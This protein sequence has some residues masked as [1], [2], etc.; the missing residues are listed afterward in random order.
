M[1]QRKRRAVFF[2]RD[3][4]LNVDTGY[5]SQPSDVALVEHAAESA[6]KLADAG[7]TL[8]I[9]SNQSGIARGMMT[10]EQADAVDKRLLAMLRERG[11]A[12]EAIYRCPHLPGGSVPDYAVDCDCR[13]P[14]PGLFLRAARELDLDLEASWVIGDSARDVQAGLAA[15]CRAIELSPN[16]K[17]S[18]SKF[19]S[20]AGANESAR[21]SN[22][23]SRVWD[24]DDL[25]TAASLILSNT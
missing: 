6:K 10:V 17:G 21:G 18:P 14:K 9:V 2:D 25:I 11:V 1:E 20:E 16:G 3:G 5:V 4:T 13:K 24:A 15:G 23:D 7:Y 19:V 8:V 12:I 22:S